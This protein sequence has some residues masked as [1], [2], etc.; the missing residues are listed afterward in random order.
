[1]RHRCGYE[2][3]LLLG[4]LTAGVQPPITRLLVKGV[5]LR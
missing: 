2:L 3:F 4:T 1:L 5:P